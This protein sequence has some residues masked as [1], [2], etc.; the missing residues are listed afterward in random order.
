[1]VLEKIFITG[2]TGFIGQNLVKELVEYERDHNKRANHEKSIFC[3]ILKN[4]NISFHP[5]RY[6]QSKRN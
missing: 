1:M 5:G 6:S 2:I 3:L 4:E